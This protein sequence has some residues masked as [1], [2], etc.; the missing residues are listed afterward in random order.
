MED[1]ELVS[2]AQD[3]DR[4][5]FSSLV[6]RYQPKV[7]YMAL[8]FTRN[9]EAADDLAQE[10]F[11]KAYLALRKFSFRSEFGT[12][13]YRITVN[14][15]KDY[16]RKKGRAREVSLDSVGEVPVVQ[17]DELLAKAEA[18][19]EEQRKKLV[20]ATLAELPEKYRVI[21][22]LRDIQGCSYEQIGDIL[23]ISPGTVDSRL[24][25]ARQLL[26]KRLQP[27]LD[28]EGEAHAL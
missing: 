7:F 27:V 4:E 19:A 16:L 1:K 12:W 28:R 21:V 9:R 26:R 2:L 10:V 13:L 15:A 25:R 24:H 23:E 20:H 18:R 5:A 17:G 6:R 22:T 11:L 8:S 3:G 14:H